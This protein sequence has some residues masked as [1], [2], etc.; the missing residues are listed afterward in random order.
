MSILRIRLKNCIQTILEFEPDMRAHNGLCSFENEFSSLKTYLR[1]IDQMELAEEDV[2]ELEN[3]TSDF[4][5]E[6]EFAR[7]RFAQ[8]QRILQ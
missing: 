3:V 7:P 4:L 8:R 1:R 5:A 6:L 2:L